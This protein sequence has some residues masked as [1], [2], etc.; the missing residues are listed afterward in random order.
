MLIISRSVG[1]FGGMW[2]YYYYLLLFSLLK[3]K[4]FPAAVRG[5]NHGCSLFYCLFSLLI[6]MLNTEITNS[7]MNPAASNTN[8]LFPRVKPELNFTG[9]ESFT[10]RVEMLVVFRLLK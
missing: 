5:W 2:I 7:E 3:A 6:H 1:G 4:V 10:G 9:V 8:I